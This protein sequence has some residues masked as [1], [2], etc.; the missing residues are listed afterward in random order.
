MN[1]PSPP[2]ASDQQATRPENTAGKQAGRF[3]KGKSG[4][5][6]GKP[7]G[8]RNR[9]TLALEALLDGEAEAI[10]RKAIEKAKEGDPTALRMCLERLLP[11]RK[12]RPIFFEVPAIST[13]ADALK[14]IGALIEAVAQG[15]LTPTE[16]GELSKMVDGY[17]RSLEATELE[18]RVS[19]L[20]RTTT[21][22]NK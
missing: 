8:A 12:D 5:P 6:A 3:R 15:K 17:V 2:S 13:G 22:G 14:A 7:K 11:A 9:T 4:N 21:N 1:K 18:R 16:A 20:E 10:T 19:E